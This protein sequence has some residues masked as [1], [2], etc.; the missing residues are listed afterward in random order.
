[1]LD[2]M[3]L[4]MAYFDS[5]EIPYDKNEERNVIEARMG[6]ENKG[7]FRVL[8]IFD[9]DTIVNIRS[10]EFCQFPDNKK[11]IMFKVC[12][13]VNANYRWVKFFVD[14]EDNTITISNDAVIQLDSCAE[15]I[16]EL[17]FRMAGIAQDVYPTF[18]KALWS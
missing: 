1:M 13:R 7:L 11:D 5:K 14:E 3:K 15:E 12:S 18:M 6:I 8:I 2:A 17:V 4:T 10:Y 16:C 9:T